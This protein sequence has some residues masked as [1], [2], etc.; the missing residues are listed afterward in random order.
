[1]QG[2]IFREQKLLHSF[3]VTLPPPSSLLSHVMISVSVSVSTIRAELSSLYERPRASLGAVLVQ[4]EEEQGWSCGGGTGR[5]GQR[6]T[7][8]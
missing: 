4:G 7:V 1:M 8:S 3:H 6:R 5:R 2:V